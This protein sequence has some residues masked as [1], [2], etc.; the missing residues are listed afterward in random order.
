M[1]APAPVTVKVLV[2]LLAPA[3]NEAFPVRPT[4]PMSCVCHG[5]G[6]GGVLPSSLVIVTT[7]CASAIVALTGAVRL[8]STVSSGSTTVSP[9][10]GT[11]IVVVVAPGAN[12]AVPLAGVP[13]SDADAVPGTIA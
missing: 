1:S 2:A 8:T 13:I 11:L 3:A 4:A 7:A 9:R 5:V 10:M 6:N 12:V